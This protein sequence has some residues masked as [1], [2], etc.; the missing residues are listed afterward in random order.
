MWRWEPALGLLRWAATTTVD[1]MSRARDPTYAAQLVRP[2]LRV[3]QQNPSFPKVLIESLEA[4]DPAHRMS[5]AT[6]QELFRG[7]IEITGDVDLGLRAAR[8]SDI[9]DYEVV[10][11]AAGCAATWRAALEVVFRYCHLMNEAAE[12]RLEVHGDKAHII[13]GS[14]VALRRQAADFQSAAIFVAAGRWLTPHPQDVAVWFAHP[15]PEDLTQYRVTYGEHAVEFDKPWDGFV[16]DASLLDSPMLR[17][18]ASLHRVLRDHAERL[19]AELAT[20]DSL[21]QQVRGD[22]MAS[23]Q[24]GDLGVETTARRLHM[25]RRTLARQLK[26]QGTS[27]SALLEESRRELATRLLTTTQRTAEEIAFLLG[28]ADSAPFARAFK[29]WTGMAPL[30]YRNRNRSG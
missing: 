18:D 8:A 27:F 26:Q 21:L 1:G 24:S 28:Y 5:V 20:D 13:L 14:S 29:R 23:L 6:A 7:A 16:F 2:F 10:E 11:Y 3:L 12:F 19:L 30:E 15:A 22:I 17:A 9:G 4:A 25:S